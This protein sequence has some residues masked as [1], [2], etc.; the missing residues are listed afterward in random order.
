MIPDL[1]AEDFTSW[2]LAGD[3]C[4]EVGTG[5]SAYDCA[6]ARFYRETHALPVIVVN[7]SVR[8]V[9]GRRHALP[10]WAVDFIRMVDKHWKG[11]AVTASAALQILADN[12]A[13]R[14]HYRTVQRT[15][16]PAWM[17][18]GQRRFW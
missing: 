7:D 3:P 8:L 18:Y 16:G 14:E 11:Q 12:Q 4:R 1:S 10:E 13:D 2:L 17:P 5:Y 15:T 6:I 9:L